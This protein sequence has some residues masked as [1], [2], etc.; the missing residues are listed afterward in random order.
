ML[1]RLRIENIGVIDAL[2][3]PFDDGFT[4]LTGE[5]GAGKSIILNCLSL[6]LGAKAD[7]SVVRAGAD[8]ALIEATFEFTDIDASRQD[9]L[10]EIPGIRNDASP[11]SLE[12]TRTIDANGRS[13][14]TV[15]GRKASLKALQH[16][17]RFLAESHGQRQTLAL[18]DA[19]EQRNV[20][21]RF[22]KLDD[23]RGRVSDAVAQLRQ[24]RAEMSRIRRSE[25]KDAARRETLQHELAAFRDVAPT[26]GEDIA[27]ER[28][29]SRLAHTEQLSSLTETSRRILG[30]PQRGDASV[31]DLLAEAAQNLKQAAVLDPDLRDVWDT[32]EAI[33]EQAQELT[34]SLAR[35]QESLDAHPTRLEVVEERIGAI[36]DLK[37]R[38]GETLDRVL[39]WAEETEQEL[40][41][42]DRD[43]E[44]ATEL[45][46][47]ESRMNADVVDLARELSVKR[48]H[49]AALFRKTLENEIDALALEGTIVTIEVESQLANGAGTDAVGH[50]QETPDALSFCDESG[51]DTVEILIAPN[52]GEPPRPLSQI[53]SGGELARIMLAIKTIL[54]SGDSRTLSLDEID[55]GVGGHV[56]GAIGSKLADLGRCQQ[57]ICV[58]HLPQVAAHADH[59]IRVFK[60]T[61][62]ARTVTR[63]ERLNAQDKRTKELAKMIGSSTPSGLRSMRELLEM[64]Q[65]IDDSPSEESGIVLRLLEAAG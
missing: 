31:S 49:A 27:L 61:E 18:L 45:N 29:Q 51:S 12:I 10:S 15:N 39:S 11:G 9:E 21:D 13:H 47:L 48:R 17:G 38:H 35:Y 24:I 44:R 65:G 20:L 54:S 32:A 52:E 34:R 1:T 59:H 50:T 42:L 62:G 56:G 3:I 26:P 40:A 16:A 53:A 7:G 2:D 28:E 37:R 36:D 63:F 60:Q 8:G 14:C 33:A 57:V 55:V 23:E 19:T 41:E 22:G 25:A 4:V 46:V 5:T 64:A 6:V 58:T 30:E 43:S